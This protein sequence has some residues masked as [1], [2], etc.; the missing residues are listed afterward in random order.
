M[1]V[2]SL[3]EAIRTYDPAVDGPFSRYVQARVRLA[4]RTSDSVS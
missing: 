1:G 3:L 4:M 2:S